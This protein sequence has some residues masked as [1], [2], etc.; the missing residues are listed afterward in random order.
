LGEFFSRR[1]LAKVVFATKSEE[2]GGDDVAVLE[3]YEGD[4]FPYSAV[5]LFCARP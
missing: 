3:V 2:D 4:L 5:H 1:L